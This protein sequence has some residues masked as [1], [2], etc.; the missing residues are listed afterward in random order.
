[1]INNEQILNPNWNSL[2]ESN[3]LITI[4][5]LFIVPPMISV[6]KH[7][8]TLYDSKVRTIQICIAANQ[9]VGA[10]EGQQIKLECHSEAYPKSI[11]YW[12]RSERGDIV[13]QGRHSVLFMKQPIL[14]LLDADFQ[15]NYTLTIKCTYEWCSP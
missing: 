1:L 15:F 13:P 10:Y 6:G 2:D 9:L 14:P 5:F 12:T 11:N 7:L 8:P 3:L 4:L